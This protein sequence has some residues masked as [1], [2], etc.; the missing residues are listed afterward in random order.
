MSLYLLG[1]DPIQYIRLVPIDPRSSLVSLVGSAHGHKGLAVTIG[2]V[3]EAIAVV[4]RVGLGH[5]HV[6]Y[7]GDMAIG[8]G[9]EITGLAGHLPLDG[10]TLLPGHRVTPLDGH[11][12]SDGEG[13]G[14]ALG[15]GLGGADSL[16]HLPG[17][18]GALGLGDLDTHGVGHIPADHGALLSGHGGAL[19]HGDTVGDGRRRD[20]V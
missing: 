4:D 13:D 11:L 12:D 7:R 14:G 2:V 5:S 3:G 1:G 20:K 10:V 8:L 17:H 19:G 18:G 15:D 9:H 6:G 16:G